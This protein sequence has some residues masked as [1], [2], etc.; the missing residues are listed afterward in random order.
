MYISGLSSALSCQEPPLVPSGQNSCSEVLLLSLASQDA[1]GCMYSHVDSFT[2]HSPSDLPSVRSS[3]LSTAAAQEQQR[4]PGCWPAQ[5]RGCTCYQTVL[6]TANQ[7][8]KE[9][10]KWQKE[11]RTL[12]S[13]GFWHTGR[14][15]G[16]IASTGAC[17]LA[18]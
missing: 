4:C 2:A 5:A 18:A 13:T 7:N 3:S 16:P 1:S 8:D 10:S 9:Q 15:A 11:K 12:I 14:Q 6:S 17:Q